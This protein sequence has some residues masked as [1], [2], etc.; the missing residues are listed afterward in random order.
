[1]HVYIPAYANV[2]MRRFVVHVFACPAGCSVHQL[3]DVLHIYHI[4]ICVHIS[5]DP[6]D[7]LAWISLFSTSAVFLKEIKCVLCHMLA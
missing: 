4:R 7:E 3:F 6:Y 1:M 2:H 5:A